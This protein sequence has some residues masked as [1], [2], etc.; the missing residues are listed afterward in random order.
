MSLFS[1]LASFSFG[2]SSGKETQ[3]SWVVILKGAPDKKVEENLIQILTGRLDVP[4]EDALKVVRAAP[5]I[6]FNEKTA[7]EAEQIKLVLNKTGARTAISND[8][9][10]FKKFPRVSWPRPVSMEELARGEAGATPALPPALASP[11]SS[12]KTEKPIV[13][14]SPFKPVFPPAAAPKPIVSKSAPPPVTPPFSMPPPGTASPPTPRATDEWKIKYDNLQQSYSQ[15]RSD[16][17]RKDSEL[18][19]LR[20][21][22]EK[23]GSELNA[24]EN[25]AKK[26]E[27]EI[28]M[29][30]SQLERYRTERYEEKVE[31]LERRLKGITDERDWTIRD[32][33]Q[34]RNELENLGRELAALRSKLQIL[35]S[36]KNAIQVEKGQLVLEKEQAAK[37]RQQ[38]EKAMED[39]RR[40]ILQARDIR[41]SQQKDINIL[42]LEKERPI[43]ELE[44]LKSDLEN[45]IEG[46]SKQAEPFRSQLKRIENLLEM[47]KGGR[48]QSTLPPPRPKSPP[49]FSSP[50]I[51]QPAAA[52][53]PGESKS[54]KLPPKRGNGGTRIGIIGP[55]ST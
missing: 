30:T 12:F 36:E 55:G 25:R 5:I 17:E 37:A 10:E 49:N 13:P 15:L 38:A 40:E 20:S 42:R 32:R 24:E 31:G 47:L 18:S 23:K 35:E 11:P 9:H 51:P 41:E 27:T 4:A 48:N 7:R 54:S 50:V 34:V 28:A 2:K 53:P 26:L 8:P 43:P 46:M 22:F 52:P 3:A 44:R 29:L 6:L 19:Q 33:D 16:L 45:H 39:L 21:Q 14:K 1:K